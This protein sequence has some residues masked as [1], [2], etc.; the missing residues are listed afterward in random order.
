MKK[1]T[2]L[3]AAIVVLAGLAGVANANN[4]DQHGIEWF[5]GLSDGQDN[6]YW[7]HPMNDNVQSH[8]HR[9]EVLLAHRTPCCDVLDWS[10]ICTCAYNHFTYDTAADGRNECKYFSIHEATDGHTMSRH[11][12]YH[13]S[14]CG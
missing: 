1:T 12:H 11:S 14:F 9:N 2:V 13:H 3:L 10:N 5:T 4:T 7:V 8:S 6:D